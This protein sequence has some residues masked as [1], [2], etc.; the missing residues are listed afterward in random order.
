M[1]N[2]LEEV[3]PTEDLMR[4]HGLL[5]RVL[6]IYDTLI[7]QLKEK[8]LINNNIVLQAATIMRDFV[9]NYHEK[10]EEAHIFTIFEKNNSMMDMVAILKEQHQVGRRITD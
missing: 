8:Q 2:I 3:P 4:E 1:K 10:Q 6:I 9:H 5:N 7:A